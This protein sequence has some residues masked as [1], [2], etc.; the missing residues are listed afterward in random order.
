M[1]YAII[2]IS[3]VIGLAG[4]I[5]GGI[6]WSKFKTVVEQVKIILDGIIAAIEDDKITREELDI[7]VKEAKKLFEL[8]KD[9]KKKI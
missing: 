1:D 3:V 2:V 9:V 5:F 4:M 6:Y 8:F 7:I